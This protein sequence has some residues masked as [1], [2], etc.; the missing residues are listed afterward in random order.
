LISV[1]C[2]VVVLALHPVF[3]I[4]VGVCE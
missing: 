2:G 3:A 4:T 1:G